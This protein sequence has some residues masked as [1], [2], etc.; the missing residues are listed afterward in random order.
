MTWK[1]SWIIF[2]KNELLDVWVRLGCSS[3]GRNSADGRLSSPGLRLWMEWNSGRPAQAQAI[4]SYFLQTR[5]CVL[6][7]GQPTWINF[8]FVF[9]YLFAAVSGVE[10][11]T[12]PWE[13]SADLRA[14]PQPWSAL[15]SGLCAVVY[16][17]WCIK[18]GTL[19]FSFSFWQPCSTPRKD[20]T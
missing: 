11:R 17:A 10:S 5:E 16:Y 18:I 14:T 12:S 7:S 13:A 4:P 3:E 2:T 6:P 8:I 1:Q 15:K 19:H 9:I 20:V